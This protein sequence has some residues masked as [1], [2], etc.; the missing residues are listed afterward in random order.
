MIFYRLILIE[1]KLLLLISISLASFIFS[2]PS[3]TAGGSISIPDTSLERGERI[4][5]P[6]NC[7]FDAPLGGPAR[8]KLVYYSVMLRIP[9]VY[10]NDTA[11]FKCTETRL[12]ESYAK[13][14][15]AVIDA[16]C[17]DF[18][19]GAAS[20][21]CLFDVE[22]LAGPDTI[23]YVR[24]DSLFVGG[25]AIEFASKPSSILILSDPVFQK[26][27][28]K[29]GNNFPNP[30]TTATCFPLSVRE[31]KK[32]EFEIYNINGDRVLSSERDRNMFRLTKSQN[33]ASEALAMND[34]IERGSYYLHFAPD[35]W[36]ISAGAYFIQMITDNA[37]SNINFVFLK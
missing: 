26:Y 23:A 2:I 32:I 18:S 29:I 6:V 22:A 9:R 20:I 12:E 13:L 11:A 19:S 34:K 36:K 16:Y 24:A 17:D 3:A 5:L 7:T 1:L 31:T 33:P 4:A 25:Q 21:V 15:S 8:L 28:E 37:V 30:F 35:Q 27:P 10:G 14:D